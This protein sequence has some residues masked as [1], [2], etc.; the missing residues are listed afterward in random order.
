M[1]M[2]KGAT[3]ILNLLRKSGYRVVLEYSF[4]DLRGKKGIPLRYDFAILCYGRPVA[5][6]E[7]DGEAHFKQIKHFQKTKDKLKQAQERDRKKNKY[8]L[9]HNIPLYR[10]PYWEIDNIQIAT[11]IFQSKF[12][13]KSKY[14]NDTLIAP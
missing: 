1:S 5:L 4:N 2:S 13:V 8:A 9:L 3:K 11:D 10:I 12:I 6:I 7:Y 14:H